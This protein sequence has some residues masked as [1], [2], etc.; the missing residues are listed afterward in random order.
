MSGIFTLGKVGIRQGKGTWSTASDVWL[1][2]SP[3]LVKES[4]FGYVGGG[5]SPSGVFS[6]IDRIDYSNDN[7]QPVT[8]S[9]LV[10]ACNA[11]AGLGNLTHG[12]FAGGVPGPAHMST[13]QRIDFANDTTDATVRG[14]LSGGRYLLSAVGNNNF[15]YFG[16]SYDPPGPY[17]TI[18]RI[19][20]SL[21][22]IHISEPTRPY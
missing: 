1:L 15:G 7:T 18:D 19:D 22:L 11:G 17:S 21:S 13:V 2:A 4:L 16:G 20:Y 9:G 5:Y 3:V 12:Y 6:N 10:K 8:R 14:P